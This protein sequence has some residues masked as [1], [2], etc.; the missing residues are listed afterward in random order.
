M[1]AAYDKVFGS[2]DQPNKPVRAAMQVAALASPWG[3]VEIMVVAVKS[4]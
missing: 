3:L 1:N 2:V 4:K